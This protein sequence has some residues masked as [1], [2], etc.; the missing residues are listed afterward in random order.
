MHAECDFP[1]SFYNLFVSLIFELFGVIVSLIVQTCFTD[2]IQK[3]FSSGCTKNLY[4]PTHYQPL[5]LVWLFLNFPFRAPKGN[6]QTKEIQSVS[7][8]IHH[9]CVIKVCHATSIF[10]GSLIRLVALKLFAPFLS[11]GLRIAHIQSG[12]LFSLVWSS[13]NRRVEL[14]IS[15]TE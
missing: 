5:L 2:I 8:N 3:S 15:L 13:S 6:T 12:N 9:M 7:R 11:P 1:P 10:R 14:P 4:V